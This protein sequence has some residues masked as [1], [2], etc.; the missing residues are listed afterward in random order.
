MSSL[1][2]RS[3]SCL[4]AAVR[5]LLDKKGTINTTRSAKLPEISLLARLRS[6][7]ES[8]HLPIHNNL[9][10]PDLWMLAIIMT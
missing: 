3:S 10:L 4:V 7:T 1:V 9:A 5:S 2:T 8:Q 6:P